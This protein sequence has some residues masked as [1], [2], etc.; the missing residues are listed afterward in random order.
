MGDQQTREPIRIT[1]EDAKE[2]Y[3]KG[4]V[5]VLDVID[6]PAYN[7]FSYQIQGAVRISP[8]NI[9]DEFIRLPKDRAVLAY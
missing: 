9:P 8:E 6:T 7:Q 2:R 1:L 5:T 3:D 4:S